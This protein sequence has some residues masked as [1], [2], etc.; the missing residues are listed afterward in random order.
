MTFDDLI[1]WAEMKRDIFDDESHDITCC[2]KKSNEDCWNLCLE[3]LVKLDEVH[4]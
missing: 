3:F 1:K 2:D 4:I